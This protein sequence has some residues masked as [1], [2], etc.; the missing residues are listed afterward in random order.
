MISHHDVVGGEE[1]GITVIIVT[2]E[3]DIAECAKRH[4]V[5]RD[6]RIKSDRSYKNPRRAAEAIR[7]QPD[8]EEEKEAA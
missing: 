6:G 3:P 1:Q 8:I 4:I 2:H 5:F 7:E